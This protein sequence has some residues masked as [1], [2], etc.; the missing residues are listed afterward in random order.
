MSK[1]VG[2]RVP[3]SLH[4]NV[5]RAKLFININITLMKKLIYLLTVLLIASGAYWVVFEYCLD[6]EPATTENYEELT[7]EAEFND[8]DIDEVLE[9][10]DFDNCD[11]CPNAIDSLNLNTVE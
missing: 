7:T 10:E 6:K 2:V 5:Q 9:C 4:K 8:D 1:G 3:L 11:G